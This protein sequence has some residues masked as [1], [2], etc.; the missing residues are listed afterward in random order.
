MNYLLV[1]PN[2]RNQGGAQLYVLRRAIYLREKGFDVRIIISINNGDFILRDKFEGFPIYHYP[3]LAEQFIFYSFK[4]L[5]RII[6]G[7][8]SD[9]HLDDKETLIES[10]TLRLGVWAEELAFRLRAK[11]LLYC[12]SELSLVHN[13][14]TYPGST[15][16]E[17]KYKRGE[18][19]GC[20][21]KSIE[22][23]FH[24]KF[25]IN[26]FVN[27]A[28]DTNELLEKSL[29]I[30][31]LNLC[32]ESFV[33]STITRLEKTY[34]IPLIKDVC[35]LARKHPAQKF[36]LIIAGGSGI[37]GREEY[38]LNTFSN[39]HLNVTNLNIIFTGYIHRLGKDLFRL[40]D[41]FVGMGTASINSISQN[42][43]TLNID[44]LNGDS[45]SGFFGVDTLNFAYPDN[46][47][48]FT[49]LEKLE[50]AFGMSESQKKLYI[51]EGA[52]VYKNDFC[53]ESCFKKL[54]SIFSEIDI[55]SSKTSNRYSF[56][57][58]IVLSTL[59]RMKRFARKNLK[60]KI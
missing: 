53:V 48:H 32:K 52:K 40:T 50:Q 33:I 21:S 43:L 54:D 37:I 25:D 19:Y 38:L 22:F 6:V 59:I 23:L 14:K 41:V 5:N 10:H 11:H 1:T 46:D 29:P 56:I 18:F 34:V 4:K 57:F 55:V 30:L 51:K 9:L 7:I 39:E 42:T 36:V 47:K 24:K 60:I 44:P 8:I 35:Q 26:N 15:F 2:V 27:I 20:S 3:E 28:F 16:F 45:C 58:H 49:I 17:Q 31:D 12:L 13:T